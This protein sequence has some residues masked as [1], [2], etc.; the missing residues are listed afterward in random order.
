MR[1]NSAVVLLAHGSRDKRW[2]AP[3]DAIA[4]QMGKR[5]DKKSVRLA[6]LQ[7]CLPTVDEAVAG[8]AGEGATHITIIPM[9]LAAGTHARKD[10]PAI[11]K[12]LRENNAG[13][14]FEWLEV[15]GEWPEAQEAIAELIIGKV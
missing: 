2:Q 3:F 6:Y 5:L 11:N 15:F 14:E 7:D 9:F 8:L 10:F 12:K 1:D 13:I 4:T